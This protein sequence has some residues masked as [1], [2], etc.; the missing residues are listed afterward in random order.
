MLL[1]FDLSCGIYTRPGPHCSRTKPNFQLRA[2]TMAMGVRR[3]VFRSEQGR[4]NDAVQMDVH[5]TFYHFYT[6]TKAYFT[7]TDAEIALCWRVNASFSLLLFFTVEKYVACRY[8]H[9]ADTLSL[10]AAF[11]DKMSQ[12][13]NVANPSYSRH[14]KSSL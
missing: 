12:P 3:I 14:S 8:E 6:K 11:L 7:A 10:V 5:E 9:S 1:G 4:K 13:H 2:S